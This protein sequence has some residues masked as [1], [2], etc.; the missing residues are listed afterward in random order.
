MERGEDSPV[1]CSL[2]LPKKVTQP[3]KK[4]DV[5][6]QFL[7]FAEAA[8][9]IDEECEEGNQGQ[10]EGWGS[11]PTGGPEDELSEQWS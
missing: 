4:G 11:E 1:S 2:N 6:E 3:R 7:A 10:P 8:S 9:C 5:R